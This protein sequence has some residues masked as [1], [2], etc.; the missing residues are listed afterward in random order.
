MSPFLIGRDRE[1]QA[2]DR[3]LAEA[4]AGR[5]GTLIVTGEAGI[6]KTALL[7]DAAG[8]A[9][10]LRQ[11]EARP[12]EAERELP[13]A[14]L[15][16]LVRPLGETAIAGLPAPQ[17]EALR[18]ALALGPPAPAAR[19][20]VASAVLQLLAL[21]A[22][23]QPLL[24]VLDDAQWLDDE[25]AEALDFALHRL[26][27]A[28]V[29]VLA[30]ARTAEGRA[31]DL[32]GAVTL[33]LSGIET[34]DAVELLRRRSPALDE[35]VGRTLAA[36]TAGNPLALREAAASLAPEQLSG[37]QPLPKTTYVGTELERYFARAAESLPEDTRRALLVAAV[38]DSRDAGVVEAAL[39]RIE[40]D[41][42]AL[43]PAETAGIVHRRRGA[44]DFDHPLE[45]SA[46]LQAAGE[47]D[48]RQAHA[49]LAHA[50]EDRPG[51]GLRLALHLAAAA[52]APDEGVAAR[53]EQE[54]LSARAQAGPRAALLVYEHAARL[55]PDAPLRARRLLESARDAV[56]AG[57]FDRAGQLLDE[58]LEQS[59]TDEGLRSEVQLLRGRGALAAG[60][61]QRA[62]VLLTAEADR[63]AD[64][65][66][67]AAATLLLESA[68]AQMATG[69]TEGLI[70]DASRARLLATESGAPT[71]IVAELVLGEGLL[72]AGRSAEGWPLIDAGLPMLRDPALWL[73]LPELVGMAGQAAMWIERFDV[74]R[75]L[76]APMADAARRAGAVRAL[77]YPLAALSHVD[78]R[79]G[80]WAQARAEATEAVELAR[81]A[82]PGPLLAFSLV[83]LARIEATTGAAD[84]SAARLEEALELA[85][86]LGLGAIEQHAMAARGLLEL[87]RQRY[88]DAAA[89][90][91]ALR[92]RDERE[93]RVG[94]GVLMWHADLAEALIRDGRP[95]EAEGVV[96]DLEAR[97]EPGFGSWARA[98]AARCRG[99]LADD[100]D[101]DD[102][103]REA[104]R[105]HDDGPL[106][107]F[108]RA[109][110]ELCFGER[111]RRAG[112]RRDSRVPLR[113][114]LAELQRLGAGPW[115]ERAAGELRASGERLRRSA[116]S[117]AELTPQELQ[118]AT[119]VAG[120]A[121]NNEAAAALFVSPKTIEFHLSRI[122]RKLGLRSRTQLARA[123]GSQD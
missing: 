97:A 85:R 31:I 15:G 109:R 5:G 68:A 105:L 7:E 47:P 40:L 69:D 110:T 111:L 94:P 36:R 42:R 87:G 17:A 96:T 57:L 35:D 104:L 103:F 119:V 48:L 112:R 86:M 108:E 80:P 28:P 56:A 89:V 23:T 93:F 19:Y 55:T 6:G 60:D 32:P 117:E 74:A 67:A 99:L 21:E 73:E 121:S 14:A 118:V 84:E 115:A 2:I 25:S 78:H 26:G 64:R 106:M 11:L 92:L 34:G 24:L 3:L 44:L 59:G 50:L 53:L 54:A 61:P 41:P 90:L 76:L 102:R 77:I 37:A 114:A 10:D 98:A 51:G 4:R 95:A 107:P 43:E 63:V 58:V 83:A 79:T 91:D 39:A 12:L 45:R 116:E 88:S 120:G 101:V 100:A 20:G 30:G 22:S 27:D 123:L 8:R 62:R 49:A 72:A 1:R 38:D 18:A 82:G 81:E 16:D 122:Y 113:S 66:P 52:P 9:S 46:L 29:A 71:R 33:P 70:A 75:G 13:Y 65:D